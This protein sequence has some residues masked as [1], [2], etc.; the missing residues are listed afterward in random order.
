MGG[1]SITSRAIPLANRRHPDPDGPLLLRAPSP[2]TSARHRPSSVQGRSRVASLTV[3]MLVTLS[4]GFLAGQAGFHGHHAGS[5]ASTRHDE[6]QAL[7]GGGRCA[8][9]ASLADAEVD[10]GL[11]DVAGWLLAA[12]RELAGAGEGQGWDRDA[13][14]GRGSTSAESLLATASAPVTLSASS[15]IMKTFVDGAAATRRGADASGASFPTSPA[16]AAASI[17]ARARASILGDTMVV[18]AYNARTLAQRDNLARF[19]SKA[20]IPGPRYVLAV[21]DAAEGVL[22]PPDPLPVPVQGAKV[23]GGLSDPSPF[24]LAAAAWRRHGPARHLVV[25]DSSAAGPFVPPALSPSREADQDLESW[26]VEAQRARDPGSINATQGPQPTHEVLPNSPPPFPPASVLAAWH[27][28]EAFTAHLRGRVRLVGSM[29]SCEGRPDR[30]DP[31]RAWSRAPTV[32]SFAWAVDREGARALAALDD[33]VRGGC[34]GAEECAAR[35]V[36][37]LDAEDW[38]E[39]ASVD[40]PD[41]RTAWGAKDPEA[42]TP[43]A[44]T[45]SRGLREVGTKELDAG[46]ANESAAQGKGPRG[47]ASSTYAVSGKEPFAGASPSGAFSPDASSAGI[48]GAADSSPNLSSQPPLD[49]VSHPLFPSYVAEASLPL[50]VMLRGGEIDC[51]LSRYRNVDWSRRA[52]WDCNARVRPDFEGSYDGATAS[53]F[54]TIFVPERSLVDRGTSVAPLAARARAWQ[55]D[56]PRNFSRLTANEGTGDA[57]ML[58]RSSG[59]AD[60]LAFGPGCFDAKY[61][62]RNNPD[63]AHLSPSELFEQWVHLGQFQNRPVNLLCAPELAPGARIAAARA[64][65]RRCFDEARARA[66]KPKLSE[67]AGN[68]PGALWELLASRDNLEQDACSAIPS[69]RSGGFAEALKKGRKGPAHQA[70]YWSVQPDGVTVERSLVV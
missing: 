49:D 22:S 4:I 56:G 45:A 70:L 52:T 43:P 11:A 15:T 36:S 65:G 61:Y 8:P 19:C 18:Y 41:A 54:E 28:T 30:N 63:I 31:S 25:V 5:V 42:K 16:E 10:A 35:A 32:S 68:E 64:R 58:R 53:P 40:A 33:A 59:T 3:V 60:A 2:A 39:L 9:G 12:A 51:L 27:W 24:A 37:T 34:A 14:A 20:A 44:K 57:G 46:A 62:A 29:I 26:R 21:A 48:P 1:S 50:A 23:V 66:A 47:N 17:F 38:P 6:L 67:E 7:A 55:D 13:F 69:P